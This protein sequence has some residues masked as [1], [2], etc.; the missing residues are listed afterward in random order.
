VTLAAVMAAQ[1]GDQVR[2]ER[3]ETRYPP[4]GTWPQ[5]RSR[6]GTIVEVNVDR[7]RP[8]LTE[9]GVLFG[10]VRNPNKN[11]SIAAGAETVWFK[12]YELHGVAPQRHPEHRYGQPEGKDTRDAYRGAQIS[13][14]A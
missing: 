10:K 9:Y 2:I 14:A 8:H 4:K 13:W 1:V 3:D 6:T 5:F 11:G 7:K 12:D